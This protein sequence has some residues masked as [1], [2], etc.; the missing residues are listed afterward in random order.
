[1][2]AFSSVLLMVKIFCERECLIITTHK[3]CHSLHILWIK[4]LFFDFSFRA[5]KAEHWLQAQW[6]RRCDGIPPIFLY[7]FFQAFLFA[8][9]EKILWFMDSFKRCLPRTHESVSEFPLCCEQDM[10]WTL[11]SKLQSITYYRKQRAF[12][13]T[14]II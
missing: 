2:R 3:M 12:G 5:S 13:I 6:W 11:Q 8:T 4:L 7:I 9:G 14:T 10:T 1:M